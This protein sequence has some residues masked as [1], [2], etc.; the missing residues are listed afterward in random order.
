[1]AADAGLTTSLPGHRAD[2]P[3]GGGRPR[4]DGLPGMAHG[5]R[6]DAGPDVGRRV[7]ARSASS[8]AVSSSPEG[9]FG[10]T[11]SL[12]ALLG[13]HYV[14]VYRGAGRRQRQA[15]DGGGALPFRRLPGR[16]VLAGQADDGAAAPRAV[17]H[18]GERDQR[19]L[20]HPGAVRRARR[21]AVARGAA[22]RQPR[23]RPSRPG[24]RR[25]PRPA[26]SRPWPAGAGR[27]RP[28][29]LADCRCTRPP[30]PGS[31]AARWPTSSTPTGSMSS[32]CSSSG[33]PWPRTCPAGSRCGWRASRPM[34]PGTRSPGRRR[35]L[36]YTMIADA[37]PQTVSESS[38]RCRRAARRALGRLLRGFDRLARLLN[39]FR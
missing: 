19:G 6:P 25:P 15:G 28:A 23:R 30:R 27:C 34:S 38:G 4:R 3:V 11:K 5:R 29:C 12:V 16:A 13:K 22:Q 32:R 17:R 26:S 31:R 9:V 7:V 35:G 14:A 33:A 1:M 10:I 21:A 18:L 20:V 2:L 8:A 37:P 39:P 36:V 24:S